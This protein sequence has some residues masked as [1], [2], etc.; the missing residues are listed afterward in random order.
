MVGACRNIQIPLLGVHFRALLEYG[1]LRAA[2]FSF[3]TK[4]MCI[5]YQA[6]S[7]PKDI[8]ACSFLSIRAVGEHS[9]RKRD[10]FYH[11]P[12]WYVRHGTGYTV[13]GTRFQDGA[14]WADMQK[15]IVHIV[16]HDNT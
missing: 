5:L 8:Y 11:P 4:R 7:S 12:E 13:A 14:H 6:S 15:K 9:P 3:K 2:I 1:S 16:D 10:G